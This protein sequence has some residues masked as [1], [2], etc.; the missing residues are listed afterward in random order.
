MTIVIFREANTFR[1]GVP[2]SGDF[3]VVGEAV[4]EPVAWL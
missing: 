3:A 1:T 2:G 4:R